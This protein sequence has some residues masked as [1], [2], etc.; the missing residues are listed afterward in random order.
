M[1]T[2][3]GGECQRIK[4]AREL[5]RNSKRHTLY[6]QDVSTSG[7]HPADTRRPIVPL[8]KLVDAGR[9]VIAVEHN[10]EVIREADGVV[11]LV[12]KAERREARSWLQ[13]SRS[14]QRWRGRHRPA[15]R[16]GKRWP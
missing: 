10:I 16:C 7:L 5:S 12:R 15:A 3:S 6:L 11:E 2:L 13:G 14:R 1:R 4:L 8:H 9:T